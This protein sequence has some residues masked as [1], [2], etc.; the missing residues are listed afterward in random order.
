MKRFLIFVAML[1]TFTANAQT[2]ELNPPPVKPSMDRIILVP[3]DMFDIDRSIAYCN[4]TFYPDTGIVEIHC[5][6]TGR[7]TGLYIS[8]NGCII[9]SIVIDSEIIQDVYLNTRGSTGSFMI[10][11][12]SEKYHG[13]AVL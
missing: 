4:Y 10:I 2:D 1:L 13:E 12:D 5:E 3:Q 7:E 11:L 9:D 6:G 8:R